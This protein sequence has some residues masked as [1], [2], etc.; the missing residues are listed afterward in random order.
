MMHLQQYIRKTKVLPLIITI[1]DK[2]AI[3]Y[4]DGEHAVH[5]NCKGHLGMVNTMDKGVIMSV[6]KRLGI[7]T[8]SS[9]E[10]EIIDKGLHTKM[11]VVPILLP[12][13]KWRSFKR[14][15]NAR[16]Q[17]LHTT[18]ELAVFDRKG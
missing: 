7:V 11:N 9:T 16:Q 17:E 4:I 6:L 12:H 1:K 8:N 14:Y 15:L 3:I 10:T 18:E 13:T 5:T 2:G